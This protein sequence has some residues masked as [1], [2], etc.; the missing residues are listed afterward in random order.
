MRARQDHKLVPFAK[1][2]LKIKLKCAR[3]ACYAVLTVLEAWKV[4]Q[5]R[6]QL[7]SVASCNFFVAAIAFLCCRR[8]ECENQ[9]KAQ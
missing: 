6:H 4:H 1:W 9:T 5:L 8:I 2:K 3:A 7:G